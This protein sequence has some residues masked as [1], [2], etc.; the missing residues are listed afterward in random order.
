MHNLKE[1]KI[2][3][4]A[5]RLT[6]EVYKVTA[7]FPPDEKF[8]LTSQLRRSAASIASNIAEGAGRNSDKDFVRF[9]SM[10]N[11]SSYELQTQLGIASNLDLVK[12][13]IIAPLLSELTEIQ[14]MNYTFQN[15]LKNKGV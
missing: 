7:N 3:N 12:D 13:D 10:A 5:M 15:S 8:G 2:W 1:L 14:K 9:L 11:G 6:T 4:K